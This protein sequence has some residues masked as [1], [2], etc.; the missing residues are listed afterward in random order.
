MSVTG[1]A[2]IGELQTMVGRVIG[3]RSSIHG[4]GDPSRLAGDPSTLRE[5]A[6]SH[7][8][9]A[10]ELV[11]A[12]DQG[13]AHVT[14]LVGG[15][16]Q[17][18]ASAAFSDFWTSVDGQVG[19][20]A[21][22]HSQMASALDEIAGGAESLNGRVAG[23]VRAI[24][25]WLGVAT[26]AIETVDVAAIPGLVNAASG[27][28]SRWRTLFSE[29]EA[30]A[31]SVPQRLAIDLGVSLPAPRPW[32]IDGTPPPDIPLP[33]RPGIMVRF[34]REPEQEVV[35]V[36]E[37]EVASVL[38]SADSWRPPISWEAP[39]PSVVATQAGKRAWRRPS[40]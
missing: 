9:L 26:V 20:L 13:R 5:L 8:D 16:W 23:V 32:P 39:Y 7:R 11:A 35:D 27:I 12:A 14:A 38:Q 19:D 24:E 28:L 36:P 1:L 29:V 4:L 3:L 34:R 30:F 17:G 6:G 18:A 37:D 31:G 40:H 10:G 21:A 25:S 33:G 2:Q 15:S 22:R